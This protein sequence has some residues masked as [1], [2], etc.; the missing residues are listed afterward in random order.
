MM[1]KWNDEKKL[2]P[3]FQYSNFPLKGDVMTVTGIVKDKR[4]LDHIMGPSH[5]ECPQRLK[6]IYAMLEDPDM[7]GKFKEVPVRPAERKEI[8]F[9]HSPS[10][11]D[12]LESTAQKEYA[13]LDAD[14]QTCAA[15]Y[16]TAL[17][18]AGGLCQA[19]SMVCSGQLDNAFALVR[20]PGHH[21]ERSQAHGFCLFNNV[22]IGA[23]FAQKDLHVGRILIVDWDLHHGNGTQHSFEE[24]PTILYFSTHQFPY[25]PGTG[26]FDEVG[27]GEGRGFTV[28]VPLSIGYGDG[29]YVEIFER[30]LK[31]ISLEFRPELILVSAGFDIFSGDPLGG[32]NV[33]PAGFAGMMRAILDIA[34]ECCGGKV[35][36]TLEGGY[37]IIGQRDSV[38]EVLKELAG[39]ARRNT[40]EFKALADQS[41]LGYVLGRVKKAH[42]RYWKS[43]S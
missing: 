11:V 16:E 25:Y 15:S 2:H 6:L 37:D 5:P 27:R 26:A 1:E 34:G 31:P 33:T 30:I 22:A 35:V 39:L 3:L 14:T 32:M 18:A 23:R 36:L 21:A 43:L 12:L 20:P 28:N 42:Q 41:M 10:Y 29:E 19:I 24:D 38:K 4:Y 8:F 13:F 7:R 9:I 40:T 17:L